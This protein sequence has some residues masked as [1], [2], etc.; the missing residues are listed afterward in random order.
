M[1]YFAGCGRPG[2]DAGVGMGHSAH[3][4]KLQ[5]REQLSEHSFR[6]PCTCR[7]RATRRSHRAIEVF[8]PDHC[9]PVLRSVRKHRRESGFLPRRLLRRLGLR[10]RSGLQ[11]RPARTVP[12]LHSACPPGPAFRRQQG[13]PL[14]RQSWGQSRRTC[15]YPDTTWFPKLRMRSGVKLRREKRV[16]FVARSGSATTKDWLREFERKA[17]KAERGAQRP[18]GGPLLQSHS[19]GQSWPPRSVAPWPSQASIVL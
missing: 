15:G 9:K 12:R 8:V 7:F 18:G 17:Q 1:S 14:H 11:R 10:Y 6:S 13:C 5:V 4:V 2:I 19:I 3:V 16:S